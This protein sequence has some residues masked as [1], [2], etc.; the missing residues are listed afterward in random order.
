MPPLK[1]LPNLQQSGFFQRVDLIGAA[2]AIQLQS[3]IAQGFE[4][5]SRSRN[6]VFLRIGDAPPKILAAVFDIG[7]QL[8]MIHPLVGEGFKGFAAAHFHLTG[9]LHHLIDRLLAGQAGHEVFYQRPQGGLAFAGV[10]FH[11]DFHHH[12]HHH[13]HPPRANQGNGAVEIKEAHA[14]ASSGNIGMQAFHRVIQVVSLL[15]TS[16]LFRPAYTDSLLYHRRSCN[17]D[18]VVRVA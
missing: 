2:G 8:V 14:G 15:H 17:L 4:K 10:K 6:Q 13:F 11:E 9:K 16:E 7:H 12:G 18:A 1:I 5:R 3:A